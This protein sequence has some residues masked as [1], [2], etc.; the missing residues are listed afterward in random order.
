MAARA[1]TYRADWRRG[2]VT[3]W[4]TTVDHKRI[5]LLYIGTSLVFFAAAGILALLMSAQLAQA[6][7]HFVTRNTYN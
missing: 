4:V 2:R 5:G 1:A 6:N 3:S 7:E